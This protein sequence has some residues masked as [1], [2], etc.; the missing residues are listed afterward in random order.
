MT[1][2][3]ANIDVFLTI[4]ESIVLQE[5]QSRIIQNEKEVRIVECK[6]GN[7]FTLTFEIFIFTKKKVQST[8]AVEF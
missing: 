5:N 8:L 6:V 7:W 3:I 2:D 1:T 4:V